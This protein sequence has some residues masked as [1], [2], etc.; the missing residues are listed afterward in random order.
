MKN[1]KMLIVRFK[2]QIQKNEISF[3]RGAVI[4]ALENNNDILFHNHNKNKFRYAYPLI[5][6]KRINQKAAIICIDEGTEAI[7]KLFSSCNFRFMIGERKQEMEVENI[8][9]HQYSVQLWDSTFKYRILNWLPL[10][11]ESYAKY[12][13]M[14]S[15]SDK[16]QQLDSILLGNILSFAKGIGIFFDRQVICRITYLADPRMSMYKGVKMLSFDAEFDCNVSIP[17]F[18]GLGKGVSVGGGVVTKKK[19]NEKQT[20]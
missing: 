2:N 12:K 19:E 16:I 15:L 7:G 18:I 10:N 17:D 5:Q 6:Y 8:K 9:A 13:S 1:T 20:I 4:H 11:Q 14:E 3:F